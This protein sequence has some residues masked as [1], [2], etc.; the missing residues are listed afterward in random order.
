MGLYNRPT[1]ALMCEQIMRDNPGIPPISPDTISISKGPFT[2]GLGASNR[3]TR[4]VITGKP[5]KGFNG[6]VELFYDRLDVKKLFAD[7]ACTVEIPVGT[8]KA[9]D[10]IPF[11]NQSLGL[12][13]TEKDIWKA[14]LEGEQTCGVE[15]A[16][17]P[18][19]MDASNP[20]FYGTLNAR[21]LPIKLSYHPN[22]GPG[23]KFLLA[24][25]TTAG[26]FGW[27][28]AT[29]F[30]SYADYMRI[31]C[32]GVCNLSDYGIWGKYYLNGRVV[33]IPK[34]PVSAVTWDSLYLAGL[35]LDST[36]QPPVD[37]LTPTNQLK[38][39]VYNGNDE[40]C[41][42]QSVL[43]S[44][45]DENLAVQHVNGA[46][47]EDAWVFNGAMGQFDRW[48][49]LSRNLYE[50]NK[51]Y[52][53]SMMWGNPKAPSSAS[54]YQRSEKSNYFPVI[55]VVDPN[56]VLVPLA[57]FD[58]EAIFGMPLPRM[59]YEAV[60]SAT[61][62]P[63]ELLPFAPTTVPTPMGLGWSDTFTIK[64][65]IMVFAD[66]TPEIP[67]MAS[68]TV[69]NSTIKKIEL[70]SADTTNDKPPVVVDVVVKP[71]N[72][73]TLGGASIVTELDGFTAP[74]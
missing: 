46:L 25:N 1:V 39:L 15:G 28:T 47:P 4:V 48:A 36:G 61:L 52:F 38:I 56:D 13:L 53:L 8:T 41:F 16:Y 66:Q 26:F 65:I 58:G 44:S 69:I 51:T 17:R 29:E 21:L 30:L 10:L 12:L 73:I 62:K 3:N 19:W 5:G 37:G 59:P 9:I 22:S 6:T 32:N 68:N 34:Y 72:K 71:G 31:S 40:H 57:G 18:I 45:D 42:L 55:R 64:P 24:G 43:P 35:A 2:D 49:I 33:F 7:G 20:A 14:N 63:I 74:V 67:P 11:I 50:T 27:V 54:L 60:I 23:N 70:I